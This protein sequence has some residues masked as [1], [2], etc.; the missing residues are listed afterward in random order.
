MSE[1]K[2]KKAAN[3]IVK[4]GILPF[5]IT[6]TLMEIMQLLYTEEEADFIIKAF[7]RRV[8]QTLEQLKSTTGYSE[9][10][11]LKNVN[12]LAEKGALFNQ[13]NSK[14]V[15]VYRLL[16]LIMVGIF[17]YVFMRKVEYTEKEKKIAK[18]FDQLF[19]ELQEIIQGK[20]EM[21]LPAFKKIP[22]IDRTVPF[23]E[24]KEGKEI[25]IELNKEIST[26]EEQILASD[27]I[28]EIINKFDDIT[29][30]HC[31]C[32]QHQDLLGNECEITDIRENCF[33]FGKS[34]R[35]VAEQG[36]GRLISKEEAIDILQKSEEAGLVH[37]AYHPHGKIERNETS[38]CNCCK[39]CCGTFN[40]WKQGIL[41]MINATNFLSNIDQEI[42]IGCGTCIEK[43]PVDAIKLNEHTKAERNP[44]W[45]IGCGVCA[46]FCPE[47]AISLLEGQ[48]TV[49]VPPP[50]IREE[51]S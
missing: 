2:Y 36:F 31:F 15:R 1:R 11:I 38:V 45:C 10:L 40:L 17:E 48:R 39:D 26:P 41:P 20:Y 37:K 35:F 29:V 43:C 21:F 51:T 19:D 4:A 6:D 28:E 42:C 9:E 22:P 5:P 12:S 8:S 18:L 46:H 32:R 47:N 49:F 24:T 7:K 44:D 23:K 30:A 14:G 34:A 3:I 13:P 16:P 33:T 50:K 27:K 25:S